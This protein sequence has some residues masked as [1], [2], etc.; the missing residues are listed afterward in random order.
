MRQGMLQAWEYQQR[1]LQL[2]KSLKD[3]R[4]Q[5]KAYEGE[6]KL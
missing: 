4:I 1:V 5:S 6:L 3:W 2:G